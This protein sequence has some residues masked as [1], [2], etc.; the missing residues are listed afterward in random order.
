MYKAW[1]VK[2]AKQPMVPE[3]V[4]LVEQLAQGDEVRPL[5]VPVSLLDLG[6]QVLAVGQPGVEQLDRLGAG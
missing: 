2:A 6:L 3:T 1:T 5:D 4:D